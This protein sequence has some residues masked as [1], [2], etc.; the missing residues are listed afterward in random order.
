MTLGGHMSIWASSIEESSAESGA[1]V[2]V[3]GSLPPAG[4]SAL[5]KAV[6]G[7]RLPHIIISIP[8]SRTKGVR[9]RY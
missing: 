7:K 1:G 2:T 3:V 9:Q 8:S 5:V 6:V 4:K